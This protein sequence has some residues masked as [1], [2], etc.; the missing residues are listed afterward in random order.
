MKEVF[1]T[2]YEMFA[3]FV[4]EGLHILLFFPA[5]LFINSC[6]K[7]KTEK[8]NNF[9]LSGYVIAFFVLCFFPLSAKFIMDY[10]IGSEVYWRMFWILPFPLIIAYA[11]SMQLKQASSE[12]RKYI[13]CICMAFLIIITGSAVYTFDNFS[14][15][16]NIYKIPQEAVDVCEI[17]S[18]DARK[19]NIEEKKAIVVNELLPYIRQYDGSIQMPYGRNALRNQ[20]IRSKN[21]R[22]IFELMCNPAVDFSQLAACALQ[23]NYRY[24]VYYKTE[25]ADEALGNLGYGKIGDNGTYGVYRW[26]G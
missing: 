10:C 25:S 2:A 9:L 17:I 18:E 6:S 5:M 7:T 24:L 26:N 15:Q 12:R 20:K 14:V 21:G 4:G 22:Q 23:E 13:L 11:F 16:E 3:Q 1:N 19:N 8:E